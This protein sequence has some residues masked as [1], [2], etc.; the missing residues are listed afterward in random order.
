MKLALRRRAFAEAADRHPVL[1]LHLVGK[2]NADGERQSARHDG[3]AAIEAM[4]GIEQMHRAAASPAAA[5][6]LAIHL[7]HD[8]P[9]RHAAGERMAMLAIGGDQGV[10]RVEGLG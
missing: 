1:A 2:R 10:V 9:H 8:V 3:I 6:D 4:L 7:G 5:L